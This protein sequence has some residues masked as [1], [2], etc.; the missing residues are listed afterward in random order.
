MTNG[1]NIFFKTKIQ[2]NPNRISEELLNKT[3]YELADF[4]LGK[5]LVRRVDNAILKGRIVET[6]CY[7][8]N[9]DKASHSYAGRCFND[10]AVKV[11]RSIAFSVTGKHQEM[12][13]CTCVLV[14]R[15][16]ISHME[17]IIVLIFLLLN[18]E[19]QY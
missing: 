1:T 7:L 11:F 4:L 18:P 9:D 16:F 15:T 6:E 10:A 2:T 3:C 12:N 8:G 13:L 14:L 19:V 5:L 17:C